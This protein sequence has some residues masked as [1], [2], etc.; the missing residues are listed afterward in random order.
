MF[1]SHLLIVSSIILLQLCQNCRSSLNQSHAEGSVRVNKCCEPNEVL[2]NFSCV[3]ANVSQSGMY[4]NIWWS[5]KFFNNDYFIRKKLII[6][7]MRRCL[8]TN[9]HW[10]WWKTKCSSAWILVCCWRTKMYQEAIVANLPLYRGRKMR[11]LTL[12]HVQIVM[13]LKR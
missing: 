6:S 2:S 12:F 9:I 11:F 10:V 3:N 8:G 1:H 5:E 13:N 7:Y 4:A